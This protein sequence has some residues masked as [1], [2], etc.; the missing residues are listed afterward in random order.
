MTSFR[1]NFSK[2]LLLANQN[3][4]FKNESGESF[5]LIPMKVKD[6]YFNENL[7]WFLNFLDQDVEQLAKNFP[8]NE[9]TSHYNF[10]MIILTIAEKRP[11]LK[12]TSDLILDALASIIPNI[13]FENKS[14]K[15]GSIFVVEEIFDQIIEIVNQILGRKAQVKINET[16][17]E[18]TQKMKAM[19]KRIQ[20]I[21][22]KGKRMNENS[23][24]FEDMFAALL[25]EFPQYQLHDLFELNIYTFYY[26]FRYVG[27]IANY[28]VSKIA[29]GN[30]LS[31]KHKYFIEK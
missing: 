31:K 12:E 11:E 25:Y 17:D 5:E 1:N 22:T 6:V 27:K 14:L 19:Q 24:S 7:I 18:M 10:I 4:T 3:V 15:I 13:H 20:N 28:E 23:T 21:K 8:N 2:V 9:V 16:D 29:A 26:L 30:G